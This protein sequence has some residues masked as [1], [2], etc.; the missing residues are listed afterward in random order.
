VQETH[1]VSVPSAVSGRS[2]GEQADSTTRGDMPASRPYI[3]VTARPFMPSK[4][5]CYPEQTRRCRFWCEQCQVVRV[6]ERRSDVA[7]RWRRIVQ[8]FRHR[9]N[10]PGSSPDK[11]YRT[12]KVG[13]ILLVRFARLS[14]LGNRALA[15]ESVLLQI[16][17]T[18]PPRSVLSTTTLSKHYSV[19]SLAKYLHHQ[20]RASVAYRNAQC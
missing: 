19:H 5:L 18:I 1:T 16:I 7:V 9:G 20:L 6:A 14:G 2:L 12:L 11:S 13:P 15:S 3:V 8:R 17:V 10:I 4:E